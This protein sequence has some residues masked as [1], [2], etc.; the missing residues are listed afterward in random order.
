MGDWLCRYLLYIRG[1]GQVYLLD[2]DN[3]VFLAKNLLFPLRKSPD[4][5]V[6]ETLA[7]SVS[8]DVVRVC[9]YLCVSL[10]FNQELV[11]DKVQ[12]TSRPRLLIYDI[13]QFMG[14]TDV[15]RCKHEVRLLC[16]DKE[17]VQPREAAV[18]I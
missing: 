4:G 9:M 12:S 17:L 8:Q 7:D 1:P 3:T 6:T 2:R 5:H 15:S 10:F 11:V 18:R 13:I 16:I 14:S